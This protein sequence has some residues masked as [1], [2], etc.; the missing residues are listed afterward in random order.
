[1]LDEIGRGAEAT[2]Y[3]TEY[4]GMDAVVK[5]RET[6]G[7][8]HPDLDAHL[9]S[10]RTRAEVRVIR[11]ARSCG[12]RSPFVYD[13]DLAEGSITMEL[14][15]GESVKHLLDTHPERKEEICRKIGSMVA[16][17]HNGRICHGDLTT[18]NM[19]M[20]PSGDIALIDFSMGST[21]I[22]T[23]EMGVDIRLLERAFSSAHSGMDDAFGII[24]DQYR[25]DMPSA[26]AV[27][28]KVEEIKG[29]ARYT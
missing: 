29:R 16:K 12:V 2:V 9:R 14:M 8:R 26:K 20:S 5:V 22:G 1:M 15:E 13:V 6:K 4:H 11:E 19:V 25:K 21:R 10:H 28:A 3:R 18:S 7:Y 27:L 23:E 17:L 24:I